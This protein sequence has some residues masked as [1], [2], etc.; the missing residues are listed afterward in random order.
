MICL[1][2]GTAADLIALA[3]DTIAEPVAALAELDDTWLAP[4]AALAIDL[5]TRCGR[6]RS[7]CDCQHEI[8]T[9]PLPGE[10]AID[11]REPSREP[12]LTTFAMKLRFD[13][14]LRP[15]NTIAARVSAEAFT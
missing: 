10:R 15:F 8:G 4:V 13:D 12:P 11:D 7:G 1:P 9:G 6:G 2:C 14:R 3:R 5:H